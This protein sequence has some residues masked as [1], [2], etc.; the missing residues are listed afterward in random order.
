MITF[1]LN[2]RKVIT[3]PWT[4]PQEAFLWTSVT[5]TMLQLKQ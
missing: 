1:I 4:N 3:S 2:G 5:W